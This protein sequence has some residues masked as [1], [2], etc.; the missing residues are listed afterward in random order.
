MVGDS[1]GGRGGPRREGGSAVDADGSV[2]N[3]ATS[4][5]IT[6]FTGPRTRRHLRH[7]AA[8]SGATGDVA[9]CC[10]R[11]SFFSCAA[12]LGTGLSDAPS[13][14]AG[15]RVEGDAVI[16][17]TQVIRGRRRRVECGPACGLLS[18]RGVG[19]VSCQL[20]VPARQRHV[21]SRQRHVPARQRRR[22][23]HAGGVESEQVLQL[24]RRAAR[25]ER[26][27][28]RE[29]PC[30]SGTMT[31]DVGAS[32]RGTEVKDDRSL[33]RRGSV[34][35]SV[36]VGRLRRVVKDFVRLCC[37][38]MFECDNSGHPAE[39]RPTIIPCSCEVHLT[40]ASLS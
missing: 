40:C 34:P 28:A 35:T 7:V 8:R 12:P 36:R 38:V 1:T 39:Q 33:R 31:S 11:L 37:S 16:W 23:P 6:V 20:H 13:P 9:R 17:L 25:A 24:P 32:E 10:I 29:R 5:A 21:L 4:V 30:E 14:T 2:S 19:L 27:T 15:G 22:D 18:C 26:D 3:V